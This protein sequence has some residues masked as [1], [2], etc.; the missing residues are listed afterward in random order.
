[1]SEVL[2]LACGG[3]RRYLEHTA[4]TVAS[5]LE[6]RGGL[7]LHVH[8]LHSPSLTGD[9]RSLFEHFIEQ[10]GGTVSLVAVSDERIE[11]LPAAFNHVTAAMWYR[12]FLPSLLPDVQR[13]LYVDA[14]TLAMDDVRPLWQAGLGGKTLGA[15]TNVFEPWNA[16]YP[17]A[18][19]LSHPYF[20]SGVLLLDLERMRATGAADEV[21]RYAVE[22]HSELTWPDQDALNVVLGDE[23]VELNPRWNCMNSLFAFESA[24]D[25]FGAEAAAEA[26]A[27]PGVRHFEGP[28]VNKPWHFLCTAPH[29]DEYFRQRARTPWPRVR[30]E[31]RTVRS[32]LERA[33]QRRR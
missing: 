18:L 19:G 2:Q 33:L 27:L 32:V 26:R 9:E 11:A 20:N 1:V 6:H 25:V 16:G 12:I 15:V 17:Q 7:Q 3:D 31:G 29:R 13:V 5:F 22:H 23:R 4:A 28:S 30:I 24:N 10:A 14:D 8:Y 21:H